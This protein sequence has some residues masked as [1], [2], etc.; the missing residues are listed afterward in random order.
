MMP[1]T[2]SYGGSYSSSDRPTS[3]LR[4]PLPDREEVLAI[5][6]SFGPVDIV[7]ARPVTGAGSKPLAPRS[8]VYLVGRW[9]C[10]IQRLGFQRSGRF[11]EYTIGKQR[12][13]V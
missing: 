7:A 12:T 1:P 10:P 9:M 4:N 6:F 5:V 11:R 3:K 13:S 8:S 2:I